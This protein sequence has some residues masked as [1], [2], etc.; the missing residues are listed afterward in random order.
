MP[1]T[2]GT[3]DVCNMGSLNCSIDP[4]KLPESKDIWGSTNIDD[5]MCQIDKDDFATSEVNLSPVLTSNDF[6]KVRN[7]LYIIL[8]Q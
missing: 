4:K 6:N 2:S 7:R 3:T 5:D 1:S 8:I